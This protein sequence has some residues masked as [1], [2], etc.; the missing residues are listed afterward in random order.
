MEQ[1]RHQ[2]QY[3]F[4]S[5]SV[6]DPGGKSEHVIA[7]IIRTVT[8]MV[9]RLVGAAVIGNVC[10]FIVR[11]A[12]IICRLLFSSTFACGTATGTHMNQ[13]RY[14]GNAEHQEQCQK[15]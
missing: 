3:K 13:V 5:D 8:G 6:L 14:A 11:A 10:T 9:I 7:A 4:C 12:A 2:G 1:V 15:Q